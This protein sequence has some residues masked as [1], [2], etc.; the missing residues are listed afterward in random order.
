MS[1]EISSN[2]VG[3]ML[4]LVTLASESATTMREYEAHHRA[5]IHEEGRADKAAINAQIAQSLEDAV[6]A[7][8][9]SLEFDP[10]KFERLLQLTNE[11]AKTFRIYEGHHRSKDGSDRPERADR[12]ASI[13]SRIE[14]A[15]GAL[16]AWMILEDR[17][18]S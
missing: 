17:Q 9:Q 8:G 4:S 18:P 2:H 14:Q 12:N 11:A 5:K 15:A 1:R 10:K 3:T 6:S 16:A 7:I 13:A